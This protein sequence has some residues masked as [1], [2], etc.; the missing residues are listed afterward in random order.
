M[1]ELSMGGMMLQDE[2]A[3]SRSFAGVYGSSRNA[4]CPYFIGPAADHQS[5]LSSLDMLVTG[6]GHHAL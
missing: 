4:R 2:D 1:K 5:L 3:T 6:T